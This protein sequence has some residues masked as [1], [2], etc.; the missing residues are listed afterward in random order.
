MCLLLYPRRK[1]FFNKRA[2]FF[3]PL[4][5]QKNF[6]FIMQG[7]RDIGRDLIILWT[8]TFPARSP[9]TFPFFLLWYGFLCLS[10]LSGRTFPALALKNR[11]KFARRF[12]L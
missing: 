8:T 6:H 4:S 3:S 12:C 1:E 10:T 11:I 9:R 7:V 2:E 5:N